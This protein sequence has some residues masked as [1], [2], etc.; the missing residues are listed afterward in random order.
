MKKELTLKQNI[1]LVIVSLLVLIV[2]ATFMRRK[3]EKE[4]ERRAYIYVHGIE[5]TGRITHRSKTKN[6]KL[7]PSY[8]VHFD[9]VIGGD[10]INKYQ[11]LFYNTY[12][13]EWAI[14]GMKYRV[15][16]LPDSPKEDAVIYIDEPIDSEYANIEE[17]RKR[18]I[19]AGG[20]LKNARKME[21]IQ[22]LIPPQYRNANK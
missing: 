1:I 19:E 11:D 14:T 12:L 3:Q 17:E 21:D 20:H 18:I 8:G 4:E 10:T 2:T 15:K 7:S 5:T 6:R 22:Y 13:Y 9:F 16:Y